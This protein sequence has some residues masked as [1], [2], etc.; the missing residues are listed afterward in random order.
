[1]KPGTIFI[2]HR[3]EYGALV[4]EL[5]TAIE[6][7]SRRKIKVFISEDLPPAKMW[8]PAIKSHLR[9]AESLFLIYGAP[10]PYE[11]WSWCFYE[12]GFFAGV[13]AAGKKSREIYC[14]ARPDV[15]PPGPLSDLQIV[16]DPDKLI[17]ALIEIYARNKIAYDGTELRAN[18]N[19]ATTGLFRK[20]KEFRNYP[21]V[22]FVANESD[23]GTDSE[24]PSSA[25]LKGD[26]LLLGQ[27]F[28]V[29]RD[30]VA[31]NEIILADA[32]NRTPQEQMFFSK[33]IDETKRIILAARNNKIITPQ[34]VLIARGG[35]R[36]RFLLYQAR[37]QGDG[38]YCCEFLVIDE[39]GGPALG[40][41]QQQ[42][43]LLTSIRLG[44]RFRE[45]IQ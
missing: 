18:I 10:Y 33:W 12:A 31:W 6:A 15:T 28:G 1:M 32:V 5:K 36:Y 43:A 41:S 40:L 19:Q 39:V 35:P 45:P 23:F 11:D 22:H 13:D 4:R 20:L 44:F 16:T 26:T 42:L 2:S 21:R 34:T 14:L 17:A 38:S 27:L 25:V 29:S 37:L 8:R 30:A 9:D 24:L 7:T 3:A